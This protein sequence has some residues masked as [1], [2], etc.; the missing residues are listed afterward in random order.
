MVRGYG[1]GGLGIFEFFFLN[2]FYRWDLQFSYTF[3]FITLVE[4]SVVYE[5]IDGAEPVGGLGVVD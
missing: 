2:L 3:T 1:W 5:E 4:I